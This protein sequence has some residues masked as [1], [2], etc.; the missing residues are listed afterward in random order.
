MQE[1][2]KWIAFK[3]FEVENEEN[4]DFHR[5]EVFEDEPFW[6]G[7]VFWFR[8]VKYKQGSVIKKTNVNC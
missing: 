3:N 5:D 1:V 2:V 6:L 7:V 4:V 8:E